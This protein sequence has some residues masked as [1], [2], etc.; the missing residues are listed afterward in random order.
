MSADLNW[1][2]EQTREYYLCKLSLVYFASNY[3]WVNDEQ[4]AVIIP[5]NPLP[6]RVRILDDLQA[7]YSILVDKCRRAGA[8]WTIKTYDAWLNNF[9]PGTNIMNLSKNEDDAIDLLDKERFILTHLARHDAEDYEDATKA[10]WMLGS[11]EVDNTRQFAI[12][13][14]DDKGRLEQISKCISLT[15]TS[16]SG[17]SRGAGFTLFDEWAFTKPNDVKIWR[18]IGPM[19]VRGMQYAKVSTANG[20]GGDFYTSCMKARLAKQNGTLHELPF[21]YHEV[22]WWDTEITQADYDRLVEEMNMDEDD[23]KQEFGRQFLSSGTPAFNHVHVTNCYKPPDQYPEIAEHLERWAERCKAMGK[24]YAYGCGVDSMVGRP[25]KKSSKKDYNSFCALTLD[26]VQAGAIHSKESIAKWSGYLANTQDGQVWIEGTTTELHRQ[27]PGLF[28]VEDNGPGI[29]VMTNHQ[30]PGDGFSDIVSWNNNVKTKP[31]LVK[32]FEKALEGGLVVITDEFT[33][34]CLLV[35]QDL[36]NNQYGAPEGAGFY[37]DPVVAIMLA[38][39]AIVRL[40]GRNF[41]WGTGVSGLQRRVVTGEQVA[42]INMKRMPGGPAV[43]LRP[44]NIRT[45]GNIGLRPAPEMPQP[46]TI[47]SEID[48]LMGQKGG[49]GVPVLTPR[50]RQRGSR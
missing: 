17:R 34:Q 13:W 19:I 3:V 38:W 42:G 35:Y 9:W 39:A 18:S 31:T 44:E 2:E 20:V 24:E 36:G 30:T 7:G 37:D 49:G 33:Y 22:D 23:I 5:F 28:Y 1:T 47:Q 12:G 46:K 50:L 4:N 14:Y 27:F 16:E 15:T 45:A 21:K 43:A 40:G 32:D 11:V 26:G 48:W 41:E 10:E 25:S 8:S 29:Q 6:Y